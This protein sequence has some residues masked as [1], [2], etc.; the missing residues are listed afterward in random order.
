MSERERDEKRKAFLKQLQEMRDQR[1]FTENE[2]A[3]INWN[4]KRILE[5]I[6][7]KFENHIRLHDAEV[8]S[9]LQSMREEL[10]VF[11]DH[12][13]AQINNSFIKAMLVFISIL[14][15]I[16]ITVTWITR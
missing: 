9:L 11:F 15:M 16:L 14:L 6:N 5:E 4:T 12:Q 1:S 13:S 10:K 2:L 8:R 7:Y 3:D